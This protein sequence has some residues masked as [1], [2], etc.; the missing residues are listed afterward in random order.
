MESADDVGPDRA[1]FFWTKVEGANAQVE[2]KKRV[3]AARVNLIVV[4]VQER[5]KVDRLFS[6]VC[7]NLEVKSSET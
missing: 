1:L 6:K 2:A 3:V 4:V 5:S 7:A